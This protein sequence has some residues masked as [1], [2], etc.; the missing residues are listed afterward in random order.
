MARTTQN[1][2][3]AKS[4]GKFRKPNTV[5]HNINNYIR[6]P[7][8]SYLFSFLFL[9]QYV[10][11]IFFL[12]HLLVKFFFH[13]RSQYPVQDS[14]IKSQE[15]SSTFTPKAKDSITVPVKE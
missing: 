4:S 8:F 10:L 3:E 9:K 1:C 14:K 12:F 11:T 15:R 2:G 6:L 7:D 13:G 5:V